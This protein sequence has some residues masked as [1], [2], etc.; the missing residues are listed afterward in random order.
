MNLLS[1]RK[2]IQKNL[3]GSDFVDTAVKL[4]NKIAEFYSLNLDSFQFDMIKQIIILKLNPIV[5]LY[6]WCFRTTSE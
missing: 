6:L 5:L 3:H 1:C 4:V 2:Y